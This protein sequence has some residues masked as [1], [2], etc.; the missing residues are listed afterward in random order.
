L[1]SVHYVYVLLGAT[2]LVCCWSL[3]VYMIKRYGFYGLFPA[4]LL[5]FIGLPVFRIL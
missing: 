4:V 5:F 2:W 3:A 1:R